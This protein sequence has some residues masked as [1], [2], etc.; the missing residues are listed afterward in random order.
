MGMV[1]EARGLEEVEEVEGVGALEGG[2]WEAL[3]LGLLA[4][5]S[6]P[7][8]DIGWSIP[9]VYPATNRSVQDVE[10]R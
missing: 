9:E 3:G 6:A 8:V 1:V 10:V 5:T 2:E 4:I 7:N